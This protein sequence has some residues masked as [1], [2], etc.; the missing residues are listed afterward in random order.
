MSAG[1]IVVI[2]V[3]AFGMAGL[4]VCAGAALLGWTTA[5]Q[6]RPAPPGAVVAEEGPAKQLYTLEEFRDLVMGK[7]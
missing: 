2:A 1:W 5:V 6:Q 3:G 4:L 7:T